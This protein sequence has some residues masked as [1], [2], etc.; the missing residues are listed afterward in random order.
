[1]VELTRKILCCKND[2]AVNLFELFG[3]DIEL[4]LAENCFNSIVIKLFF[5]VFN[6]VTVE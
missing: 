5:D 4:R 3:Y 2:A 1:M 6:I